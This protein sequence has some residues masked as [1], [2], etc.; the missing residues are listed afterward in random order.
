MS[1]GEIKLF[2]ENL[3]WIF[4]GGGLGAISRF[5]LY[6]ILS[7]YTPFFPFVV[8]FFINILGS[9]LLGVILLQLLNSILPPSKLYYFWIIGFCASLTTFSTFSLELLELIEQSKYF[10]F[11]GYSFFSVLFGVLFIYLGKHITQ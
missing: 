4:L 9:F 10:V 3:F 2:L 5:S 7:K 1:L 8:T 11:L 6:T